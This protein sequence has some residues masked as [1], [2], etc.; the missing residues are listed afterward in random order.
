MSYVGADT[1]VSTQSHSATGDIGG[2]SSTGGS[3]TIYYNEAGTAVAKQGGG[4][5][6]EMVL[7]V[8][9]LVLALAIGAWAFVTRKK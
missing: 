6:V 4:G 3:G 9:G 2:F 8:G 7:V 1:S 5:T